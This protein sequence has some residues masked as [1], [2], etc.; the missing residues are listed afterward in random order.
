MHL[1]QKNNTL[2]S[3][4]DKKIIGS[5]ITFFTFEMRRSKQNANKIDFV[6][7]CRCEQYFNNYLKYELLYYDNPCHLDCLDNYS[8]N[9]FC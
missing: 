4:L 7:L 8:Q 5:S 9:S 2:T 1:T 6:Y 3:M